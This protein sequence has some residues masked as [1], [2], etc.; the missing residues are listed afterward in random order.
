[1]IHM[2]RHQNLTQVTVQGGDPGVS[3]EMPVLAPIEQSYTRICDALTL[4][5]YAGSLLRVLSN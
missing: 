2:C 5:L 1:M 3:V 4:T